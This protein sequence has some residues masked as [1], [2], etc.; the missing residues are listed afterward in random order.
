[1]TRIVHERLRALGSRRW[2]SALALSATGLL[3]L[4]FGASSCVGEGELEAYGCPSETVF[5]ENVSEYLER[6]CGTLDCHGQMTRPMRIYGQLGLRHPDES[7]V[8]GGVSTTQLELEANYASVCNLDP[9]AM[10]QVVEDVGSTA[11]KLLLVNKARGLE[12]HKGGKIVDP[13]DPGDLCILGWLGFKE[14][15]AVDDACTAAIAPLK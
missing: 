15:T 4:G 2:L 3:G 5:V 6:R 14:A 8:S 10:Q 1:M 13:Q 9:A 11:D 7:N 12:R